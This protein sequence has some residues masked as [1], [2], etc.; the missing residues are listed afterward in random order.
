VQKLKSSYIRYFH[1]KYK[2]SGPLWRER[3]KSLLI[4][5]EPYLFVCGEYIENN[6]V[7]AG[8]ANLS[9]EYPFGSAYLKKKK[10][11]GAEAQGLMRLVGTTEVV[12]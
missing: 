4:E 8:L 1:A 10:H 2:L 11:A 5:N 6:P 7:K 12:P 3:Y 9:E